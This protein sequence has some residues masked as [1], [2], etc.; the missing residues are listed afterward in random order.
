MYVRKWV[1]IKYW[2]VHKEGG[3]EV[4]GA[5]WNMSIN[6]SFFME[7]WIQMNDT[8]AIIYSKMQILAQMFNKGSKKMLPEECV[9]FFPR[10]V[11]F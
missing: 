9:M 11:L 2:Y 10:P 7:D 4:S 6:L 3:V 5:V 8:M 1:S